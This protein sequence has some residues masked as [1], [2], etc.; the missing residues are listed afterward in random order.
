MDVRCTLCDEPMTEPAVTS[1]AHWQERLCTVCRSLP[2]DER[3]AL[4]DRAMIRMIRDGD[5]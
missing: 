1:A 2:P 5:E 3:K 4:R